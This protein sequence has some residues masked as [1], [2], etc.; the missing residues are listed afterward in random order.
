MRV[1]QGEMKSFSLKVW[2]GH[3]RLGLF[4]E[5]TERSIWESKEERWLINWK[6]GRSFSLEKDINHSGPY[7]KLKVT[8][9]GGRSLSIF[10][11][12]GKNSD[13]GQSEM[14]RVQRELGVRPKVE[15]QKGKGLEGEGKKGELEKV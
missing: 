10:V 8:E 6:E 1:Y 3:S 14:A 15:V 12:G 9:V 5:V 7:I 11:P 13:K 4:L 2:M